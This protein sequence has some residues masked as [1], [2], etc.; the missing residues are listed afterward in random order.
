MSNFSLQ[1]SIIIGGTIS[2]LIPFA[3]T[4]GLLYTRLS[5]DLLNQSKEKSALIAK[6]LAALVDNSLSSEIKIVSTIAADRNIINELNSGNYR[7]LSDNLS[8]MFNEIGYDYISFFITDRNGII[9]VDLPEGVRIGTDLSDRSYFYAARQGKANISDPIFVRGPSSSKWT[10]VPML[11]TAAPIKLNN[12]FIGM[13]AITHEL[14]A[15]GSKMRTIKLGETGYAYIINTDGMAIIHPNQELVMTVNVNNEP[16]M[17][18]ISKWLKDMIPL[19]GNYTFRGTEKIAGF[20]PLKTKNWFIIFTQNRDEIMKPVNEMLMSIM[21]IA[22]FFIV[23]VIISII[24]FSRRIS[25]PVE[26]FVNILRQFIIHTNEFVL[27]IGS[28]KKIIFANPSAADFCGKTI[29]EL[30]GTKPVFNITNEESDQQIWQK[31]ESGLPWTGRISSRINAP[32]ETIFEITIIQVKDN[33]GTASGYLEFGRDIS[34][35]IIQEKRILQAQ[36][37]EAIGTLAGGI[38]HDFNNILTGIYGYID[39]SLLSINK[40]DETSKYL[41]ELEKAAKRAGD[42]VNQ[43]LTFS[44]HSKPELQTVVPKEIVKEVIKLIR[45]TTPAE[46]GIESKLETD[47]P[48]FADPT[49]IH[50]V[51]LN[52]ST[53]AIHAIGNNHGDIKI[54]V[55]DIIID[56]LFAENHPGLNQGKHVLISISDSGCGISQDAIDHIFDPF[57]TTKLNGKGT[58]LGLSVAHGIIHS[59]DGI[60]TVYSELKKGTVFNVIIPATDRAHSESEP[61]GNALMSGSESIMLVD[62][63]QPIANSLASILRSAGYIVTE[64]TDSQKALENFK[65]N[66]NNYDLVITDYSM[67]KLTGTDLAKEIKHYKAST[68]V[69]LMSGFVNKNMEN[70]SKELGVDIIVNKPVSAVK[71]TELIRKIMDGE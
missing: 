4:A 45:A 56:H 36:K 27:G 57:F 13:I 70:S 11:I 14:N 9:K 25:T 15:I 63:E 48:I 22:V 23:I 19:A 68:P 39:L 31:L 33:K 65:N 5:K 7:R 17:K 51:I 41:K 69:I 42:L 64:F 71:L 40:P 1:R 3:I 61:H 50:Q 43:I 60:I 37:M 12:E 46:I 44:R 28:D 38:A 32:N 20:A 2:V 30:I 54:A 26:K 49:Q 67:P 8:S 55:E 58:G 29:E 35:E 24:L 10:G 34:N 16:G 52:L 53:N 21:F 6:D 47:T 18:H 66:Y 62:D 59:I